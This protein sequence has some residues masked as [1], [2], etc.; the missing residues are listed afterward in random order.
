MSTVRFTAGNAG[1]VA[2][3]LIALASPIAALIIFAL[4]AV[5]YLFEQLPASD[6]GGDSSEPAA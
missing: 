2:G 3:T 6:E 1:Y 4:L 5:Y